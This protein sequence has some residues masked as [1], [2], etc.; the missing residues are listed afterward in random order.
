MDFLLYTMMFSTHLIFFQQVHVRNW[1]AHLHFRIH[2]TGR[3]LAADGLGLW[4]TQEKMTPG[5]V[6]GSRDEFTGLGVFLDT[7]KN[8]GSAVSSTYYK[9]TLGV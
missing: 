9:L 5:P 2:G 8:G 1:E 4:Y 6:F 3:T 7:Y